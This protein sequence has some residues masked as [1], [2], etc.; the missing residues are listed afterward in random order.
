MCLF[1]RATSKR[2]FT[3]FLSAELT[4]SDNAC[5]LDEESRFISAGQVSLSLSLL[6]TAMIFFF[7]ETE[8]LFN[9]RREIN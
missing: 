5:S 3:S 6:F 8:K 7:L 2:L 4:K 9:A 1:D